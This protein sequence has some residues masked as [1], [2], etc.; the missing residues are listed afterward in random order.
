MSNGWSGKMFFISRIFILISQQEITFSAE[1]KVCTPK[2]NIQTTQRSHVRTKSQI[3][4]LKD[5]FE[6]FLTHIFINNRYR[7]PSS[8]FFY[9]LIDNCNIYIF[10]W[11]V[12]DSQEVNKRR[13]MTKGK[14]RC[15]KNM[16][17]LH[18]LWIK[19]TIII[20]Y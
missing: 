15:K 18:S 3:S 7:Q 14:L 20:F 9:S 6:V 17:Q 4:H 1:F 5:A 2:I 13:N 19:S 12:D 8:L 10:H 11:I 16:K